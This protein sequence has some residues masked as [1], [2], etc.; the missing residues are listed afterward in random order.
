[1]NS[2]KHWLRIIKWARIIYNDPNYIHHEFMNHGAL[3][4]TIHLNELRKEEVDGMIF[5]D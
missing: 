4:K 5:L 3:R 2:M 1:M